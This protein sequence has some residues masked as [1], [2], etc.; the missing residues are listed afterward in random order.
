[1]KILDASNRRFLLPALGGLALVGLTGVAVAKPGAD[2][3]GAEGRHRGGICAKLSCTEVQKEKVREVM[4]EMRADGKADREAI[5]RLHGQMAAE[6]AKDAPDEAAMRSIQAEVARHKGE[7]HERGFDAMMEIHGLLDAE[8]RAKM[9]EAME[10]HGPKGMMHGGRHGR[11]GKGKRG[12]GKRA[13]EAV[14][15]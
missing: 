10:R 13:P 4:Q 5:K 8:Q 7:L 11:R 15:G 9:A 6:F 14:A 1:M 12:K 3:K 2:A